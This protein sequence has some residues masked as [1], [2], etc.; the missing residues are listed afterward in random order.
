[1]SRV[2]VAQDRKLGRIVAIKVFSPEVA[3]EVKTERFRLEI[4]LAAKLQHPHIVPLLFAGENRGLLYFT[5]PFIDG[6]SLRAKLERDGPMPLSDAIRTLRHIA[7]ALAYAHRQ[8]VVH[9]DIKPDNVLLAGEFALVTDFGVAKALSASTTADGGPQ[10]TSSGMA[11][12]TPAYMAPEQALADPSIDHRADIYAFGAVAYEVL[13]GSPPFVAKTPQATLAAHVTQSPEAIQKKRTDVPSLLSQLVMKCLEKRP[14]DRPQS[15]NEVLQSLDALTTGSVVSSEPPAMVVVE[16]PK[17][18]FRRPGLAAAAGVI[19]LAA[20]WYALTSNPRGASA[21]PSTITSLAVLPL[22]NQGNQE[23][24]E[25]FS[26]GMT[27]ELTTALSKLPELRVA[28]R[29]SV[30]SFKDTKVDI[31]EIGRRLNVD[32]VIEGTVR[33]A[34][35]QLRVT[36]RL[37]NAADGLTMWSDTYNAQA[38]DVFA[39]QDQI[40]QA[41]ASAIRPRLGL[42]AGTFSSESRGTSNLAAWDSYI[43]GRHFWNDRGAENLRRAISYFDA[44]IEADPNFARAHAAR[45][46]AYALLPEYTDSPPANS[47]AITYASAQ[48]ALT[49]DPGL[50]EAHTA[51]GLASVHDWNYADA[52]SAYRKAIQLEPGY[53]TAHQWLG[54][55]LYHTGRVDS[56]IVHI[57]ESGRL[58]PLA[59]IHPAAISYALY[60]S[61]RYDEAL[62]EI[63]RGIEI[64]PRL[65]LHHMMAGIVSLKAGRLAEAV[66]SLRTAAQLEPELAIRQGYL[67]YA[68]GKSGKAQE[69]REIVSRLEKRKG[70]P[71]P[72]VAIAIGYLGLGEFNDALAALEA[73]VD[74]HDISL[75]TSSS[76]VPDPIFDPLRNTARYQEILRRMNFV[77]YVRR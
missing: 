54:E 35:D 52:E 32:A 16:K 46:I 41:I 66:K 68:Y 56:S 57:R 12:G 51:I 13:T 48:R 59:P 30:Y 65:G 15:A 19:V 49:I 50:A 25:Y 53:S 23:Q 60:L 69:A 10:L 45:A 55:L 75:T 62:R 47:S 33:R 36:A 39:V 26:D 73:A 63:N 3:A 21:S 38:T 58:D 76:L 70:G 40:A 8:G 18:S 61:G 71:F 24:D 77:P 27:D 9:R 4:Q 44:A 28:S 22:V 14:E 29:T 17:R 7:S 11:I 5:M 42:S 67:A 6:E 31:E 37:V 72:G 2:F 20:G 64:A 34:G 74:A 43:R 1:M